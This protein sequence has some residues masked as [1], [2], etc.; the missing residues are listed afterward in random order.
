MSSFLNMGMLLS[1]SKFFCHNRK[2][3]KIRNCCES[4]INHRSSANIDDNKDALKNI[5][6][7]HHGTQKCTIRFRGKENALKHSEAEIGDSDCSP[8]L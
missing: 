8:P 6:G 2:S 4:T 3:R 5:E 1:D 7:K